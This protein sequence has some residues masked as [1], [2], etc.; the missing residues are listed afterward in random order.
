[1]NT[2]FDYASVPEKY[3]HCFHD[4]CRQGSDCLRRLAAL[5][6]PKEVGVLRCVNPAAYPKRNGQCPYFRS[7]EKM[8]LAWGI[9]TLCDDIPHGIATKL[10]PLVR[11]SFSKP[12]YYRILHQERPLYADEQKMIADLFARNG[13]DRPPVYERYTESYDWSD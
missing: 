11:Q 9:A 2:A 5:H 10:I 4:G 8:R 6:A 13:A 1:M 3:V 12:T 7:T